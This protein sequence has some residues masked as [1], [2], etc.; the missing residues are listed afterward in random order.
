MGNTES[1]ETVIKRRAH[2]KFK[3]GVIAFLGVLLICFVLF[4]VLAKTGILHGKAVITLAAPDLSV[5]QG[6]VIPV[7]QAECT[8]ETK[9]LNKIVLDEES[10]YTAE[11]LLKE[12]QQGVHYKIESKA[13]A[14]KEGIYKIHIVLDKD[15]YTKLTGIWRGSV[16]LTVKEGKLTVKNLVGYWQGNKFRRY[17]NSYV[18]SDFVVSRGNTYYIGADGEKVSG[19]QT[20]GGATYYFD[21]KGIMQKGWQKKDADRYYMNEKGA[22][23]TG[24][25]ELNG[26]VYYFDSTG[27]MQTGE[28]KIGLTE[29]VFDADGKLVSRKES[30][31]D[32]SKPMIALTFDDGPGK[33]TGELLDQLEKYNAHAT[34]FMLGQKIP[35]YPKEVKKMEKIGCELGS[36]SYDHKNM[37]LLNK[38]GVKSQMNRTNKQI[39]AVVGSEATVMRPPYGAISKVMRETLQLPMI[40]WNIDTLDWKTRDADKTIKHVM[41]NVKDGDII[42]MHDIHSTSIDA[43]LKLIPK[44]Q[45]EGYQLVTVSELAAAKKVELKK[46]EKYTDF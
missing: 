40:L 17:D 35:S 12:L 31:V 43:A 19:W 37:A 30:A 33:R 29:C 38:R 36:H 16:D 7:F 44:L 15:F 14:G 10:G 25:Q 13:D 9:R 24:W 23:L 3:I 5:L 46:G 39:K 21:Q 34:F 42:L 6:E 26:A 18:T 45:K 2:R 22:A 32:P 41:K 4:F 28:I 8:S 20:I 11:N 27:K 1:R